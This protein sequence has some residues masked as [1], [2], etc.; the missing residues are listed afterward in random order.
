MATAKFTKVRSPRSI[1]RVADFD[2]P[3]IRRDAA[4]LL[5]L[6]LN[7]YQLKL[8]RNLLTSLTGKFHKWLQRQQQSIAIQ[9][10]DVPKEVQQKWLSER[11]GGDRRKPERQAARY[12][13]DFINRET[14][15]LLSQLAEQKHENRQF[16]KSLSAARTELERREII[17]GYSQTLGASEQQLADDRRAFE[18]WFDEEAVTDRFAKTS[19]ETELELAFSFE[20][21][22]ALVDHVVKTSIYEVAQP[23]EGRAALAQ[24]VSGLWKRLNIQT[25]ILPALQ[26]ECDS[27]LHV[28]A[29]KC[30]RLATASI[31]TEL[32][33][34][35]IEPRTLDIVHRLVVEGKAETWLQCEAVTILGQISLEFAL[36]IFES[37]LRRENTQTDDIFVR[38]H[39]LKLLESNFQE[40]KQLRFQS[41][42]LADDPSPF[43]RQQAT[44]LLFLSE[45]NEPQAAWQQMAS[46]DDDQTVRAS[47]LLCIAQLQLDG[48]RTNDAF[49]SLVHSLRTD[50]SDFV[51]RTGLHVAKSLLH[52][53]VNNAPEFDKKLKEHFCSRYKS[54]MLPAIGSLECS[55]DS[56]LVR[57]WA[58]QAAEM[59]RVSLDAKTNDLYQKLKPLLLQIPIGRS[60]RFPKVWF[61]DFTDQELGRLFSVLSQDDFGYDLKRGWF[62]FKVTRGPQFVFRLW[63][64]LFEFRNKATDK[65]Q[66]I[67][68]N[69]GRISTARLR[70]Q[71]QI[72]GELSETKVPGE[73]LTI[74][75]DGTWRP[76]LPLLDDFVSVLNMSW[77]WPATVNFFSSQ[78][79][80]RVTGPA[81]PVQ[82]IKAAWQ[83]NF[84]FKKWADLRNWDNSSYPASSYIE[85]LRGMGF[86]IEF[87]RYEKSNSNS[88]ESVDHFFRAAG[89]ALPLALVL[90]QN[91][92]SNYLYRFVDYFGAAFENSLEELIVFA[93][94]FLLFFCLKHF[95]SN[96]TFRKARRQIPLSIGGWGTRGKSGTERL[97]AALIGVLGHGVVSKTT[98]CEA[99]FIH[100]YAHGDPIEI[101]LFRPYDKATIWEQTDLIR[102]AARLKPSVFLWECMA[103]NP[104]FVDLLQRQWMQDDLTTIT[105]TYPDHEDVQGPAG[106]NVAQTI[107]CFVP[108]K[109]VCISTEQ[110]M[111]P[112]VTEECRRTE[113]QFK[114]VGW[115]ESGLVSD[116]ILDRFPYQEHPDNIA[117]VATLAAYLVIEYEYSLKAMADFLVPDLGVLKT[118]EVSNVRHRKI[119]FT[120]GCSANERFGCMGNWKRLG[121]DSQDPWQ[122]PCTWITGV[123]NNRA[124]RVPRSK[125][126]ANIIVRDISA[127]RFFLIGNNLEGLQGFIEEAWNEHAAEL[128]LR[129]AGE[130]WSTEFATHAFKQYAWKMRQPVEPAHVAAKVKCM[131]ESVIGKVGLDSCNVEKMVAASDTIESL[132]TVFQQHDVGQ[133]TI[134]AIA[135]HTAEC[136]NALQ[137][138]QEMLQ[139]IGSANA[140]NGEAI[141]D[142]FRDLMKQ[143][144]FRK[145]VVVENYFATGE[146]VIHTIVE[147]TPPGFTNRMMGLQNIK[148]TGLDFVYRFQA[149]DTCFEAC[150]LIRSKQESQIERGLQA[151]IAMPVIGQLCQELVSE[152]VAWCRSSKDVELFSE[153]VDQLDQK[154]E[155]TMGHQAIQSAGRDSATSQNQMIRQLHDWIYSSAEQIFDVNDS[156]RRRDKA[157]E[158]YEDLG[159]LRISR[160]RA[161][162]E[163][164][165]LTK[166]QKG[167]WLQAKK[168]A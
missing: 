134:D 106:Y 153:L 131:I 76:F 32:L 53:I 118:H 163:L 26:Q 129:D 40:L 51:L 113:T 162:S 88:D 127:D 115:L 87:S 124:D 52:Q 119:E 47:A 110:V 95:W 10:T 122:E 44:R 31:P 117:L 101:P 104:S 39:I 54:E 152:T 92:V 82:R 35:V 139:K 61:Q 79:V 17:L 83:L 143:W 62:G 142:E 68:H 165:A 168:S 64:F 72:L 91:S 126:F 69:V 148:G 6:H 20:R 74:A 33:R 29:L 19:G 138:Y 16:R 5:R 58:A 90:S 36:P 63:R 4:R 96:Y 100:G 156:V 3:A 67:S 49:S 136:Q 146:D 102:L 2:T 75:S 159:T 130:D 94:L 135:R 41:A 93:V 132:N 70:A 125:V 128:S 140:A 15:K 21:L 160:Q 43:V 37:R 59:I 22:G 12:L 150:K 154:L 149:W 103:L 46:E 71:S 167:G 65:R 56:T 7:P 9:L 133:V 55:C 73:P 123:V 84:G 105:N 66:G 27:R 77:F 78:G 97:K 120:N 86:R 157:D 28:A 155:L 164:R 107:A 11:F 112:Y 144:Y 30:L 89:Y 24:R 25:R 14:Q 98:G 137:E 45:T 1:L 42:F 166:R 109:S 145:L 8:N 81:S 161:I 80:T 13:T 158:I 85:K 23:D 141:E 116:D 48:L 60:R 108:I 151:L 18:R 121:F 50:N 34:D 57:R 38:R 111:R 114:G 147:S 99:M